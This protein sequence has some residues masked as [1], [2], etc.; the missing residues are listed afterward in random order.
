MVEEVKKAKVKVNPD[1]ECTCISPSGGNPDCSMEVQP[2]VPVEYVNLYEVVEI[3]W[4]LDHTTA[5]R[6]VLQVLGRSV[7]DVMKVVVDDHLHVIESVRNLGPVTI[8]PD[9]LYRVVSRKDFL[10]YVES[11]GKK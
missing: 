2:K 7:S 3:I 5:D 10:E 1:T 8:M 6:N 9:D 4:D 11:R